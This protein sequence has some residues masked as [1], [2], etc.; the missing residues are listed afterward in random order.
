MWDMRFQLW[1]ISFEVC[2]MR[3]EM[4]DV[5]C[6]MWDVRCEM[7]DV[8]Y[9]IWDMRYEVWGEVWEYIRD[10]RYEMWCE[11]W[12]M[13]YWMWGV[14]LWD[15]RFEIWTV[16]KCRYMYIYVGWMVSTYLKM[17]SFIHSSPFSLSPFPLEWS[18][19]FIR[20]HYYTNVGWASNSKVLVWWLNRVQD[21]SIASICDAPSGNCAEVTTYN[22][23]S[24]DITSLNVDKFSAL[25]L[26]KQF[27]LVALVRL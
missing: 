7:W 9:E 25:F 12:D 17:P 20:E 22:A 21:T 27:L 16:E 1:D 10:T 14:L 8:R 23:F 4:W 15:I 26:H 19:F 6:E 5:R 3:Y 2:D 11:V 18:F 24:D 13:G